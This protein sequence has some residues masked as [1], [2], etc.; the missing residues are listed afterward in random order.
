[1]RVLNEV[2]ADA[3]STGAD[4]ESSV[5]CVEHLFAAC[6]QATWTG[7]TAGT[8]QVQASNDVGDVKQ[9]SSPGVTNW[10]D[11][12]SATA[13]PAGSAASGLI[14]LSD[15]G[16][17]WLRVKFTRSAGT[18]AATIRIHAKGA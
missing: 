15:I 11:V 3:T 10:T 13:A 8:F 17:K 6:I 12:A 5:V 16:Y 7:T 2:L 18:G 4:F 1:M 14:H 9:P